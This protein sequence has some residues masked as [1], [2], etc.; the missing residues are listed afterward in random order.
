MDYTKLGAINFYSI[1]ML[2]LDWAKIFEY[3]VT[4]YS[5]RKFIL[6]VLMPVSNDFGKS[7][8]ITKV[9]ILAISELND[10]IDGVNQKNN[11]V[12]VR[13]S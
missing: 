6:K 8:V 9:I 7:A 10:Y 1:F 11:C 13:V 3:S 4:F 12:G 2:I 5:K